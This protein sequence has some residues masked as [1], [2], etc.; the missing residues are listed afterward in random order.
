MI[1]FLLMLM[2]LLLTFFSNLM[3][4]SIL[5]L[6]R[7]EFQRR[8]N[9]NDLS[10]RWIQHITSFPVLFFAVILG[11]QASLQLANIE[12]TLWAYPH[13]SRFGW[14]WLLSALYATFTIVF[15][16]VLAQMLGVYRANTVSFSLGW[17]IAILFGKHPTRKG[18]FLELVPPSREYLLAYTKSRG[19][20]VLRSWTQR[21]LETSQ[22]PA[23]ILMKPINQVQMVTESAHLAEIIQMMHQTGFSRFPLLNSP[24][25][26]ARFLHI[27]DLLRLGRTF[28]ENG[29]KGML[30]PLPIFPEDTPLLNLVHQMNAGPHIAFLRNKEGKITG[31]V[32]LE[33][34][35]EH[36]TKTLYTTHA[37]R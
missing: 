11:I 32:A 5:N 18:S 30:R 15:C 22:M 1:H 26:P 33:D 34:I 17:L 28:R 2:F 23:R 24:H 16:E 14:G 29:W 4:L 9:Q 21:V 35:L 12:F 25:S 37:S 31:M 7:V 27:K 8:L 3:E 19:S 10:A 13:L 36:F 6:D 20:Q